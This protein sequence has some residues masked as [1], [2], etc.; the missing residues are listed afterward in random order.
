ME[1]TR[2]VVEAKAGEYRDEEPLYAVEQQHVEILPG[3]LGEGDFGWRDVEWVVR[4]HYRRYLGE[5]PDAERRATEER[6]GEN[7]Y[8]AIQGA[9][10]DVVDTD[11]DVASRVDRLTQLA[12]VDVPV[13]S[14]FLA[15]LDPE[16]YLVVGER[17]WTVLY[18]AGELSDPYPDPPTVA[19]YESYLATCRSVCERFDCDPW[20]LYRALWR[21]WKER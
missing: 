7:G 9:L 8:E 20:A 21:L 6:F 5:Y 12:G 4:W 10:E 1:F 2:P 15:F 16:R 14:A 13:A 18:E 19:D 3:M 17:E 11:D